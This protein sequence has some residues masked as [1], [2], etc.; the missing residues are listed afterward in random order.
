MVQEGSHLCLMNLLFPCLWHSF[1]KEHR[2]TLWFESLGVLPGH[3]RHGFQSPQAEDG[4]M[5]CLLP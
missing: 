4:N 5:S 2:N 3:T 1:S